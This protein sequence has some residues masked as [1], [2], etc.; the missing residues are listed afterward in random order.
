MDTKSAY[1]TITPSIWSPTRLDVYSHTYA[2][3]F[4]CWRVRSRSSHWSWFFGA[5]SSICKQDRTSHWSGSWVVMQGSIYEICWCDQPLCRQWDPHLW[6][7]KSDLSRNI[8]LIISCHSSRNLTICSR[9][10]QDILF[11]FF[12]IL[13]KGRAHFARD[14]KKYIKKLP[15]WTKEEFLYWLYINII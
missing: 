5:S 15:W 7:R 9:R 6:D 8:W 3:A 10:H 4:G 1:L 14:Q 2:M 13:V 12:Q 11:P